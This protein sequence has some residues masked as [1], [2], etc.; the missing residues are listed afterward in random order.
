MFGSGSRVG[1]GRGPAFGFRF[2]CYAVL[3]IVLMFYDRKGQ[4][5]GRGWLDTARYGLQAAIY[6]L[7]LA[8]NSPSA[9]W[10]WLEENFA[11][12][13]AL[14]KEVDTLRAE[15]RETK[16]IT[17]RQAALAR[18]NAALRGLS[19]AFPDVIEK[20][21]V[22]EVINVETSTL[23]QRLLVNRGGQ[24]SIYKS[25]P[26]VSGDGVLGQVL[27]Y[28]PYSSEI[29]LITDAEH[30]LP[31]QVLRSGVRTI[32]LGTG[33]S[34][35]LELPY[36]PQNYDVKEGDVLV[37]SGLGQVFPYGLP[38]ARVTKVTRDPTQPLA[39]IHAVPLAKIDG[40]R[41][42]LFIWSRPNHP[43]APATPEALAVEPPKPAVK[44]TPK[45]K[46]PAAPKPPAANP[47]AT[48]PV[49]APTSEPQSEPQPAPQPAPQ[50]E[51]QT[52]PQPAPEPTPATDPPVTP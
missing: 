42:V 11:T 34:T 20:R 29:I 23:R 38:V 4:E 48:E 33:R 52:E 26:V 14:Q 32:A 24:S 43:A 9:A 21:L 49:T 35:A 45:P 41:E 47:E 40:D 6:P 7:Q 28:G 16:L 3:S 44:P 18:E 15:L 19:Q 10:S 8:V 2:F 50:T 17:M 51:P 25:Q 5:Q 30:A 36:V 27:R 39:Q 22:G 1:G 46:K 12:R 31:V 37:T 13:A